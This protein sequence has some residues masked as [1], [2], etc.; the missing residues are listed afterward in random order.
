MTNDKI[1][2]GLNRA[3]ARALQTN[4]PIVPPR[5]LKR[6]LENAQHI[7]DG[8]GVILQKFD[9][10]WSAFVVDLEVEERGPSPMYALAALLDAIEAAQAPSHPTNPR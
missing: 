4:P 7:L 1:I 3:A 6:T 10:G 5:G 9:G 2:A 8:H